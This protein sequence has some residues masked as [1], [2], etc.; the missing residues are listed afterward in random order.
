MILAG[1][2]PTTTIEGTFIVITALAAI[3]LPV[4]I[5]FPAS[6]WGFPDK[7]DSP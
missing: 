2:P 4:P 6:M 3:I 5:I 7:T 1:T